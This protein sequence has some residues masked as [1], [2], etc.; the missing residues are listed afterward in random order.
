LVGWLTVSRLANQGFS[1]ISENGF[2]VSIVSTK[3]IAKTRSIHIRLQA[4]GREWLALSAI[5][6]VSVNQDG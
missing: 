2:F 4:D 3:S 1:K 5:K 6:L